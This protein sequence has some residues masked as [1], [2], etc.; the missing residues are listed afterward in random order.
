MLTSLRRAIATTCRDVRIPPELRFS[1]RLCSTNASEETAEELQEDKVTPF[2]SS[3][4]GADLVKHA[5]KFS[6]LD[7]LLNT[8][9]KAL[10]EFG[11][12][13]KKRKLLLKRVDQY[14]HGFWSP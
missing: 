6:S 2:L 11:I 7:Q 9:T 12:D 3:V 8:K 5:D 4:G 14:K 13:C 10:K 1:N